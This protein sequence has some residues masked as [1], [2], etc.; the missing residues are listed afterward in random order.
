MPMGSSAE[1]FVMILLFS[2]SV[3]ERFFASDRDLV[4]FGGRRKRTIFF[5]MTPVFAR[6][7]KCTEWLSFWDAPSRIFRLGCHIGN[8]RNI[9]T[10][11]VFCHVR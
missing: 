4:C 8:G 3:R 1:G 10:V 7:K 5:W 2:G 6:R 11:A 9:S